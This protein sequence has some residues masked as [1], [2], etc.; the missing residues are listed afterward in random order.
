MV[1]QWSEHLKNGELMT[2]L[3]LVWEPYLELYI[4]APKKPALCLY[5]HH[6]S[7][8][9]NFKISAGIATR[10]YSTRDQFLAGIAKRAFSTRDQLSIAIG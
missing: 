9:E 2:N 3:W 6:Q 10:A 5:G 4:Y 1:T 7:I 8:F